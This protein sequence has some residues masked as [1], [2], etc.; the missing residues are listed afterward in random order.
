MAKAKQKPSSR[1]ITRRRN[2]ARRLSK[3]W[4]TP[5]GRLG[6]DGA[7]SPH[8]INRRLSWLA[9]EWKLDPPPRVGRTPSEDLADY[10]QHHR[11]SFDWMLGGCLMGLKKMVDE[12]RGRA[13]TIPGAATMVAKYAQLSPEQQ[14][15]VTAE[16][17]RI[18]AERG[19]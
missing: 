9:V 7:S 6:A 12:R 1:A 3:Q 15:I 19:L 14:A 5:L 13:A 4:E 8:N 10:C 11:I 16:I 18:M 17:H 2:T